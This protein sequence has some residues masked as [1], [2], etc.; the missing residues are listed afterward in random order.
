MDAANNYETSALN[1]GGDAFSVLLGDGAGGFQAPTQYTTGPTPFAVA[2]WDLNA[3]G[4]P[5]VV[6]PNWD[7]GTITVWLNAGATGPRRPA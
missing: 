4:K 7:G 3:D 2:V 1:P 5:D 6:T